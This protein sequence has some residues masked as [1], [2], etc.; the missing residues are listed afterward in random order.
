MIIINKAAH[1]VKN[2]WNVMYCTCIKVSSGIE[3]SGCL[4]HCEPREDKKR[5][6]REG[7]VTLVSLECR[8]AGTLLL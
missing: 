3:V 7:E 5:E 8:G 4:V 6:T 2:A 1:N